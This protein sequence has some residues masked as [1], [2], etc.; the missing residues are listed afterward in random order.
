MTLILSELNI[1]IR[2]LDAE[3]KKEV[4]SW[5]RVMK[6]CR[7]YQA[8]AGQRR[9]LLQLSDRQLNDIGI[10]RVDAFQ[11]ASKPFWQD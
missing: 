4:F 11:E 3:R 8:R 9:Q 1:F 7:V 2:A 6:Q 5:K 10:T